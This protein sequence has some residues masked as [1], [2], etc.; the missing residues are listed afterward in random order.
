MVMGPRWARQGEPR[1][2]RI[3]A[4]EQHRVRAALRGTEPD[5][6]E[7]LVAASLVAL[8]LPPYRGLPV[9]LGMRIRRPDSRR[10]NH[11]ASLSLRRI[12]RSVKEERCTRPSR[13]DESI[14]FSAALDPGSALRAAKPR[15]TYGGI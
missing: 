2:P 7:V 15:V 12:G 1:G 4:G 5:T 14:S 13:V 6:C 3:N 10:Q 8:T 11:H 9:P